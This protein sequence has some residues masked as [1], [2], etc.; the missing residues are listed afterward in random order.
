MRYRRFFCLVVF[1][2]VW[3]PSGRA[4]G[5]SPAI[6]QVCPTPLVGPTQVSV[7]N[8]Y[9]G[10]FFIAG[11]NFPQDAFITTDGPLLLTG[12]PIINSAGT[13]IEQKYQIGC[14]GPQQGQVFHL[15]VN[16]PGNGSA[17]VAD[18][19]TLY[20]TEPVFTLCVPPSGG[21]FWNQSNW[22]CPASGCPT[23][24]Y[25]E[26][27]PNLCNLISASGDLTMDFTGALDTSVEMSDILYGKYPA[28]VIGYPN[29]TYG[30]QPLAPQ[31]NL[32]QSPDFTL[33]RKISWLPNVWSM[34]S[35]SI[36][37]PPTAAIDFAY[38]L[39]IT[40]SHNK[41]GSC[42]KQSVISNSDVELMIWMYTYLLPPTGFESGVVESFNLPTWVNG[43][44]EQ[45][46]WYA[47]VGTGSSGAT[48]VS[49]LMQNP[50]AQGYIGVSM[51]QMNEAMIQTL[52]KKGW[53][54][55]TLE[56]YCFNNVSL[57]SEFT[58]LPGGEANYSYDIS[59]NNT[60]NYCFVV[61]PNGDTTWGD[62]ACPSN[63][64]N[65]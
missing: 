28:P 15:W 11:Q 14:C 9:R 34:V 65:R 22:S 46:T 59:P 13:L 27:N 58:S 57:G 21:W 49:L 43:S 42:A 12:N 63:T 61:A 26:L 62:Y 2:A 17:E 35:Y 53:S 6:T 8:T 56:S 39:W 4:L 64:G 29:L 54:K 40:H 32:L 48:T 23:Q 45:L 37:Q 44:L 25:V 16:A 47:Y 18:T 5:Q 3:L 10:Y 7:N 1:A 50:I 33:P 36:N 24:G 60:S 30:Y 55:S 52:V 41:D 31:A 19:I 51:N 20:N 38:D